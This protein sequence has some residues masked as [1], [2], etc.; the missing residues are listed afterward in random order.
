MKKRNEAHQVRGNDPVLDI[1]K[2]KRPF[3]GPEATPAGKMPKKKSTRQGLPLRILQ[4][5]VEG[6]TASEL[7]IVERLATQHSVTTILLQETYCQTVGKLVINNYEL[8]G[9][10]ISR[11]HGLASFVRNNLSWKL[12]DSSGEDSDIE[13][14]CINVKGYN[15]VNIYKPPP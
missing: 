2:H 9:H 14:Q 8:A 12:S 10:T 7:D 1:R 4:L 3:L 15:I 11:K 13:W 6:L 5:N